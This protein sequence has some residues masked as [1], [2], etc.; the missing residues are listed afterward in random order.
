MASA[1]MTPPP[2]DRREAVPDPRAIVMVL[3]AIAALAVAGWLIGVAK[4]NVQKS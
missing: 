4:R 2:R 3:A 1:S